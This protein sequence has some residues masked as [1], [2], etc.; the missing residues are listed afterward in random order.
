[1]YKVDED[2]Q[3]FIYM[4]YK[5]ISIMG[6]TIV[7][8]VSWPLIKLRVLINYGLKKRKSERD[9]NG[10]PL[11]WEKFKGVFLDHFVPFEMRDAKVI[12]SLKSYKE[13]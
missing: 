8:K 7:E 4:V 11:D 9:V 10:F 5:I 1:M 13:I 3:H 2:P 12:D 6:F